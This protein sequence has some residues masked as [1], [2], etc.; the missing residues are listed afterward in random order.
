MA[1]HNKAWAALILA[2]IGLVDEFWVGWG[3]PWITAAAFVLSPIAVW[4]IPN[5]KA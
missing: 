5:R 2:L 4:L 3:E 1:E